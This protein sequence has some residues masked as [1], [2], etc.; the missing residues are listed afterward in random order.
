MD[1]PKISQIWPKIALIGHFWLKI[2][3]LANVKVLN[4]WNPYH[5]PNESTAIAVNARPNLR[6]RLEKKIN[7]QKAGFF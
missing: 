5:K 2:A 1:D 4:C 3:R 7:L 6:N